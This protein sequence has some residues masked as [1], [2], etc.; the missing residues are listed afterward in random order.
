MKTNTY[1]SDRTVLIR[2]RNVSDKSC[3]ENQ[4]THPMFIF[5]PRKSCRLWECVEKYSTARQATEDSVAQVHY[6]MDT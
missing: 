1:I 5:S 4:N 3:A 6:V 2:T